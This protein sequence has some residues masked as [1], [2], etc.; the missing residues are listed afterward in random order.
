MFRNAAGLLATCAV[1]AAEAAAAQSALPAN[2]ATTTDFNTQL[3]MKCIIRH[4]NAWAPS[5]NPAEK[6]ATL[7]VAACA[8]FKEGLANFLVTC[9]GL[10][11]SQIPEQ[12]DQPFENWALREVEEARAPAPKPDAP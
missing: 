11:T 4:V 6:V 5:N 10:D 12:V 8:N 9:K 1:L 3:L 7:S 2:C